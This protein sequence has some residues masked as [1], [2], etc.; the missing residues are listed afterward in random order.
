MTSEMARY[1]ERR[2]AAGGDSGDGSRGRKARIKARRVNKVIALNQVRS[3]ID[4]GCGDGQVLAHLDP[5]VT[6]TGVDVSP[7]IL[8][9]L[10][11][12]HPGRVFYLDDTDVTADLAL[13]LDVLF[14]FPGDG[15]DEYLTRVFRSAGRFVLVHSTNRDQPSNGHVRH[16]PVVDDI[17]A[18]FPQWALTDRWPGVNTCGFFVWRRDP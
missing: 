3:V 5:T 18:R 6:Y 13:S 2:Y 11:R 8:E 10:S 9:R 4:W 14:H 17:T 7:T 12:R 1:W 16:R 15:Y